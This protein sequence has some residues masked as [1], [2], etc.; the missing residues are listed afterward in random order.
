M[1]RLVQLGIAVLAVC[2]IAA[3]P[4]A[5]AKQLSLELDLRSSSEVTSVLVLPPIV[6]AV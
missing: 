4:N 6:H 1:K 3:D 2:A 5:P